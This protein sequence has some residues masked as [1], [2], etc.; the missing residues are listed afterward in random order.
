MIMY[1]AAM[2]KTITAFLNAYRPFLSMDFLRCLC[3]DFCLLR[4]CISRRCFN[5]LCF[6]GGLCC[7]LA[8]AVGFPAYLI[9]PL[10]KVTVVLFYNAFHFSES[11]HKYLHIWII[12]LFECIGDFIQPVGN[13]RF[14]FFD[15]YL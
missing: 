13:L 3:G 15:F 9:F 8:A 5:T 2:G 4:S 12:V 11:S 10:G 7:S 6:S 14:G 1:A